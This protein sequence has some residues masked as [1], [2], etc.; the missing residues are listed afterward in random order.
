MARQSYSD[1]LKDPKWQKKRLIIFE[2]DAWTCQL[3]GDKNTS[4]HAHHKKYTGYNPWDAP[5]EDLITY[6][7]HCHAIVG[8]YDQVHGCV[9]VKVIKYPHIHAKSNFLFLVRVNGP[10]NPVVS[11]FELV[12]EEYRFHTHLFQDQWVG[13]NELIKDITNGQDKNS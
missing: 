2:R 3:C 9:I 11:I 10:H 5:D 13:I 8:Y 1:K 7:E 4:L 6:C 12:D